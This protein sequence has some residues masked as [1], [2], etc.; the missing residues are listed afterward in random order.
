MTRP[1]DRDAQVLQERARQLARP[2]TDDRASHAPRCLLRFRCRGER[3][4]VDMDVVHQVVAL[5]GAARLPSSAEPLVA[6]APLGDRVA[7]VVDLTRAASPGTPPA[8]LAFGVAASVRGHLVFLLA[9]AVT[10]VVADERPSWSQPA[11]EVSGDDPVSPRGDVVVDVAAVLEQLL[12]DRT[13]R[14]TSSP[15]IPRTRRDAT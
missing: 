7:P 5:D 1:T 9:D 2:P 3:F 11:D 14:T 13:G 15:A 10:G 6:L 8:D 4:A 12:D